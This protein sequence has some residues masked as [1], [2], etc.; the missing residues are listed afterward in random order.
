MIGLP[1][2]IAGFDAIRR[3]RSVSLRVLATTHLP[4][5][6][7]QF[8]VSGQLAV[9]ETLSLPWQGNGSTIPPRRS[10]RL[11]VRGHV[12]RPDHRDGHRL[13]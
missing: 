3:R 6:L 11:S 10:V 13:P 12:F 2:K 5:M 7:P 4:I 8:Q 9:F 1:P